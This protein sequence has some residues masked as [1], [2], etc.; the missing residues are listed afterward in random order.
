[1]RA[2]AT[3]R[4][5]ERMTRKAMVDSFRRA[6]GPAKDWAKSEFSCGPVPHTLHRISAWPEDLREGPPAHWT[7]VQVRADQSDTV[8]RMNIPGIP[9]D[10][11][12]RVLSRA[13]DDIAKIARLAVELPDLVDRLDKRAQGLQRDAE[14]ILEVAERMLTLGER[15]ATLAERLDARAES[16]IELG[17]SLQTTGEAVLSRGEVSPTGAGSRRS[18]RGSTRRNADLGAGGLA[19]GTA[20]G[21]G[22]T[23]W[24]SRGS[25][26]GRA[27][28]SRC[29]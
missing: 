14:L 15:L 2:S 23:P 11:P 25:P 10:L 1:M 20:R 19:R 18:R 13:V 26:S 12:P 5:A 6:A 17:G 4:T 21:R 24:T 7:N 27:G 3:A 28:S 16:V 9:F 8:A 22:R 29:G